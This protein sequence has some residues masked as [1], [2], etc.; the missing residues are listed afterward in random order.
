ML[1]RYLAPSH[2]NL[3]FGIFGVVFYGSFIPERFRSDVQVDKTIPTNYQL[4]TDLEIITKQRE[5]HFREVPTA[6]SK[7]S[8]CP[9]HAKSFKSLWWVD[10][11]GCSH[12]FWHFFVVL[13]VIGHY[14]AI[15]DMFAK[16]WIL[17]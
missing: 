10:Y 17:S 12:T 11:F 3:L 7:C 8:S 15:L 14:R 6:H 16:R 4:S 13:G 9:S 2:T 5:I 1:Q